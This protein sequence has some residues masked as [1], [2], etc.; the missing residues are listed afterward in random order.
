MGIGVGQDRSDKREEWG[1][2]P[3]EVLIQKCVDPARVEIATPVQMSATRG[4][5]KV[6]KHEAYTTETLYNVYFIFYE[7]IYFP[8]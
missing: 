2:F 1:S 4:D 6:K 5:W 8:K 7:V 3:T